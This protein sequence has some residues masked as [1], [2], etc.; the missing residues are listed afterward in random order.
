M[1]YSES[2]SAFSNSLQ[3][4]QRGLFKI[5]KGGSWFPPGMTGKG[6]SGRGGARALS[7][8]A[9]AAGQ[10]EYREVQRPGN[11]ALEMKLVRWVLKLLIMDLDLFFC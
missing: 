6:Q 8:S 7:T 4:T 10:A 1:Y 5:A 11:G 2:Q 9:A 3:V